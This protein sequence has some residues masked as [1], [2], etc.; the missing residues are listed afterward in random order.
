MSDTQHTRP[1]LEAQQQKE[2]L[3]LAEEAAWDPE[4]A[5]VLAG[6]DEG[7]IQTGDVTRVRA[8]LPNLYDRIARLAEEYKLDSEDVR[9][10]SDPSAWLRL[11]AG[12]VKA[13][14]TSSQNRRHKVPSDAGEGDEASNRITAWVKTAL[15]DYP[16]LQ[17]VLA[18]ARSEEMFRSNFHH[19]ITRYQRKI[20]VAMLHVASRHPSVFRRP[21]D[22]FE[23]ALAELVALL[24]DDNPRYIRRTVERNRLF[25]EADDALHDL[26]ATDPQRAVRAFNQGTR[27]VRSIL[28]Y[29]RR[30]AS[31]LT[32]KN[33]Y[34]QE[35]RALGL[36]MK[37]LAAMAD[38]TDTSNNAELTPCEEGREC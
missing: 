19:L 31:C 33:Y 17:K 15:T 22:V 35:I 21:E 12:R 38:M 23:I 36:R 30:A 8:A 5:A 37:R 26:W 32:A 18:A 16:A 10:G 11:L 6:L 13:I 14:R 9:T 24:R 34:Q 25:S 27:A 20:A 28:L 29:Q 7:D 3:T 2:M 1:D 4:A